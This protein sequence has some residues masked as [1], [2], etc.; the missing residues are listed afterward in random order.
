MKKSP[1]VTLVELIVAVAILT[2][3]IVSVVATFGG[4]QRAIQSSKAKTLAANLLQEKMQILKQQSYYAVIVTSMPAFNSN[5]HPS[6]PYDSG[7]FPPESILEGGINFTRLTYIQGATENSNKIVTLAPDAPDAGMRLITVSVIWTQ[8]GDNKLLQISSIMANP[9]TVMPDA[10]ISGQVTNAVGGAGIAGAMVVAAQD[11][12]Y[13]D[14]TDSSGNYGIILS[15]GNYNMVASSRGFFTSIIPVN[16]AANQNVTQPFSL[17]PMSSGS[18]MGVAWMNTG[19]IISQVVIGTTQ[20]QLNGFVAEYVELF[21]PTTYPIT[22]GGN[23]PPIKLNAQSNCP[24][25]NN[26]ICADPTYGILLNYINTTI[27]SGGY[28]VIANTPTFSAGGVQVAADAVYLDAAGAGDPHSCSPGPT[29]F[30]PTTYNWNPTGTPPVKMLLNPAHDGAFWLNDQSGN[31]IDGVGWTHSLNVPSNCEG[32]C[33]TMPSGNGLQIPEQLMRFAST[34]GVSAIWGPSY[35][36]SNNTVDF[37]TATAPGAPWGQPPHSTLSPVAAIVAGKVPVGAVISATD[38]LSS[39]MSATIMGSPPYASFTLTPIATGTWTVYIASRG[40]ECLLTTVPIAA[41]G[42]TYRFLSTTTFLNQISTAGFIVGRV[43]DASG[44]PLS[45]FPVNPGWAGSPATTD[46]SGRYILRV[47]TGLI[48]VVANQIGDAGYSSSYIAVTSA[49][50]PV[51]IGVVTNNVDF[52]LSQ[53]GGVTGF[54]TRDGSNALPGV[55]I[56]LFDNNGQS[57][58]QAISDNNGRFTMSAATGNYTLMGEVDSLESVSPAFTVV[59]IL[60][61]HT[62]F[63]ATFTVSGALGYISGHVY[64]NS[65]PIHSGVLILASTMTLSTPPPA[66]STAALINAAI[67]A[68]SSLEDGSYTVGVRQSTYTINAY[69]FVIN[70]TGGVTITPKTATNKL[71]YPGLTVSGVDF[72]W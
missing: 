69:Y 47:S 7:Y 25:S 53:G 49:A 64:A 24:E 46:G 41:S 30:T 56:A 12:G 35:D 44:I 27:S 63:S 16:V 59:T 18:V 32:T 39:P 55:A 54:V 17:R 36:S 67:Y 5:Y 68:T 66:L 8:G 22:I 13:Q 57:H 11:M 71:V 43:T 14:T 28:Y 26:V 60:A 21:N 29:V 3:G 4:I 1:G 42:S 40:Y 62:V 9:N 6:V 31:I 52:M 50:V 61:G 72:S 33:I 23:P 58:D 38:T 65:Q 70:S 10:V 34:A 51:S 20:V 2:A 19:P 15:P 48:D 45:G 37:A